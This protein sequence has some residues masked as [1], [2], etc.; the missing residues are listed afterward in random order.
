MK[1]MKDSEYQACIDSLGLLEG[2]QTKLQYVCYRQMTSPPSFWDGK[3]KSESKKGLLVLTNDNLIF[4]QQEG[5]W[6]SNYAQALRIP[7]EHIS[8]VVSGGALIKH[9]RILVGVSGNPVQHE[10]I[11]F[12]STYGQQQ[13]HEVRADIEKALKET[14]EEKK[15]LAQEALSRGA[16]PA[17]I[18][19]KY[20][21]ARNK[22]DQPKCINCGATLN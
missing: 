15:R 2:E 22:S 14:R 8:G 11:N 4:M 17:M 20:C 12:V 19:C 21:G 7:L 1:G 18:F 5:A 13:I 6:S 9:I 3:Q 10:F 16:T